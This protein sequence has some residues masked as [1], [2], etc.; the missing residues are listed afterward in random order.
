MTEAVNGVA[1]LKLLLL[2][3]YDIVR[4]G[5][6]S[7]VFTACVRRVSYAEADNVANFPLC[8]SIFFTW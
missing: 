8:S 4:L 2:A 3:I 5:V 7:F 1:E 6:G